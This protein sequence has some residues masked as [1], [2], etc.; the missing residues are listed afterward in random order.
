[1]VLQV[2]V[3]SFLCLNLI[4]AYWNS[5]RLICTVTDSLMP[6]SFI[7]MTY[8]LYICAPWLIGRIWWLW[9]SN[10]LLYP[11]FFY[12]YFCVLCIICTP[13][14]SAREKSFCL[15]V[16][17]LQKQIKRIC[18][19]IYFW[20]NGWIIW[21]FAASFFT[22]NQTFSFVSHTYFHLSIRSIFIYIPR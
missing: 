16:E 9:R 22:P 11:F 2:C 21:Q 17:S 15:S 8:P 6:Q 1:M 3:K 10:F 14:S 5:A 13:W 20:K 4:Y 19:L 12:F 18:S 7:K